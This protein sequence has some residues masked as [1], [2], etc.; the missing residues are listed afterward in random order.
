MV[1]G[2]ASYCLA[3]ASAVETAVELAEVVPDGAEALLAGLLLQAAAISS[4]GAMPA[5]SPQVRA[6]LKRYLIG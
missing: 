4:A 5:A 1:V 2:T 6:D 3:V